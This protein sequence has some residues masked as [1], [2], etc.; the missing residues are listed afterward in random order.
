MEFNN[1]N[2][3]FLYL[4]DQV[5]N[6]PEFESTPRSLM[7]R[8]IINSH[9]VISDPFNR[10]VTNKY[11]KFSPR[12][13]IGEWLWYERGSN[14]LDEISY[15]SR[16]WESV[17]DDNLTVN[18]AYGYR[19]YGYDNILNVNQWK[20]IIDEL[21]KDKDSRRAI[22]FLTS[23]NDMLTTTKDFPCTLNLQFLIR[24]NKLNLLVNMRSNDLILGFANDIFTFTLFQEKM[25]IQ[26]KMFYPELQMGKYYHSVSSLHIYENNFNMVKDILEH[27][28]DNFEF[29]LPRMLDISEI[30]KLQDNERIMRRGLDKPLINLSDQFCI[31]CQSYLNH[32]FLHQG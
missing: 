1:V 17:S 22:I 13:G 15:Y 25:L 2:Q 28:D 12:Y 9:I 20:Y 31:A 16:F 3:A 14:I 19:I 32:P 24:D 26:L 30:E 29:S 7:T 10:F 5:Y 4:A 21:K 23:P 11:R 27:K 18:S 8:E 6:H